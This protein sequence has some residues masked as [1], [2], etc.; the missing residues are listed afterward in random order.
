VGNTNACRHPYK[1]YLKR[2]VVPKRHQGV[3][4]LGD[5]ALA[6]IRSDLPEMTGKQELVAEGIKILWTCGL[7]GLAEAK[8]RGFII[9]KPD[10]SWDF[11]D[12]L[13]AAGSFID[14]AIKGLAALGLERKAKLLNGSLAD[15]LAAP[16]KES[17]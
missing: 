6:K 17:A 10:G 9:T 8:E 11:Q 13:K 1:T 5:D 7:L 4:R 3:L 12:G 14:K 2:R 15:L 16:E